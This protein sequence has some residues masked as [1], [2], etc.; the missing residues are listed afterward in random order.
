MAEIW[1][2]RFTPACRQAVNSAFGAVA[3]IASMD[4]ANP[5]QTGAPIAWSNITV[6]ID[7]DR[8]GRR[9]EAIGFGGISHRRYDMVSGRLEAGQQVTANKAVRA[10]QKNIHADIVTLAISGSPGPESRWRFCSSAR[11]Q[12]GR[13]GGWRRRGRAGCCVAALLFGDLMGLG[14]GCFR[15]IA[16]AFASLAPGKPGGGGAYEET[17]Q[18]GQEQGDETGEARLPR[19]RPEADGHGRAIVDGEDDQNDRQD[20]PENV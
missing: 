14:A 1:M 4:W 8:A 18:K 7:L 16:G 6:E 20:Q 12:R 19:Q 5:G 10:S 11:R 3:W 9:E 15:Q 13:R 2:T 17:H